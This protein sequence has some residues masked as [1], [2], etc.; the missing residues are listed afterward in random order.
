MKVSENELKR[1]RELIEWT[2]ANKYSE[3]CY[4]NMLICMFNTLKNEK[5][6]FD[7]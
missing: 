4:K 5:I 2:Y 1:I 6:G 7:S 3:S